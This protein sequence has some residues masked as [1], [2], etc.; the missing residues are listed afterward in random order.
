MITRNIFRGIL[1]IVFVLPILREDV[2]A[3]IG[4][5]SRFTEAIIE[6][7]ETGRSYNIRELGRT[8]YTVINAGDAEL[9]IETIVEVP[10]EGAIMQGYEPVPDTAWI[11]VVPDKFRIG[12]Q[13]EMPAD[14]IIT[15]PPDEHFANRHYQAMIWSKSAG[16]GMFGVG[17]RSRLR[18]STGKAPETFQKEKEKRGLITVNL[19]ITPPTIYVSD[20]V[21]GEKYDIKKHSKESLKITNRTD[22]AL[23]IKLKCVQPPASGLTAGYEPA[24]D[25]GWL[26]LKP[27]SFT[28][29]ANT[30]R[31][32]KMILKIPDEEKHRNKKYVFLIKGE[33]HAKEQLPV[34]LYSRVYVAT[35]G[36]DGKTA[37][38][39]N[40]TERNETIK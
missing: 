21:P 18:F 7:L 29:R 8:P 34:E 15:I 28:I 13:E 27:E 31:E 40:K 16:V 4:L 35:K 33:V 37:G 3:R 22:S 1:F 6:N 12:P 30:I 39:G 23:K 36:Q 11:K 26:K 5:R 25:T 32:I 17:V 10:G 14:V 38:R 24:Q 20:V 19:D 9:E 2:S